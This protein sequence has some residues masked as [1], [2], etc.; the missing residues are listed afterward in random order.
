MLALE[1]VDRPENTRGYSSRPGAVDDGGYGAQAARRPLPA[2]HPRTLA[3]TGGTRTLTPEERPIQ[4]IA[5]VHSGLQSLCS[6][7]HAT[8]RARDRIPSAAAH[9]SVITITE[10]HP[11]WVVLGWCAQRPGAAMWLVRI[12]RVDW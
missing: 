4:A 5:H 10:N 1:D 11:F 8:E 3:T 2:L 7:A 6:R 12:V 9:R